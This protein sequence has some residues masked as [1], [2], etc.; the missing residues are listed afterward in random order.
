MQHNR[1]L[2]TTV[3]LTGI[4]GSASTAW[5]QSAIIDYS[6]PQAIPAV[7]SGLLLLLGLSL[8]ALGVFWLSRRPAIA[9][10]LSVSLAVIGGTLVLASS[11]WLASNARALPS[12]TTF[13][14]SEN[15]SP[16]QVDAFPAELSNN[17]QVP[18]Q[19]QSISISGCPAAEQ[20][21][22][23]CTPQLSLAAG[24]GSC[25]IDS[26]CAEGTPL[27]GEVCFSSNEFA[28][29]DPW[30]IC[31]IDE[32]EAWISADSGGSYN[33]P[34][35]CQALGYDAVGQWGG[36]CGKVCGYCEAGTTSCE[37]PGLRTFDSSG[38]T[39]DTLD[40][41]GTTVQWTC[42]NNP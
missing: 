33:A 35:I 18:V 16:V 24:G 12:I 25:V 30:V 32:T 27:S 2:A 38:A 36:T 42:V 7:G 34:A 19:L 31:D 8:A 28:T 26:I 23:T 10:T 1:L 14:L 22:G 13:L 11:G 3:L 21:N 15:P 6:L 17:L 20:L 5:G 4:L 9:R 40:E 37:S 29:G 39:A 41:L